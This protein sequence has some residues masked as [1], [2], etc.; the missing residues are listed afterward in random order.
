MEG[1]SKRKLMTAYPRAR[2][3]LD[4]AQARAEALAL[5]AEERAG[6]SGTVLSHLDGL[7]C[8]SLNCARA[9]GTISETLTCWR[10]DVV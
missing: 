5:K 4:E 1:A 3:T 6:F 8:P 10:E 7:D 9:H 2:S